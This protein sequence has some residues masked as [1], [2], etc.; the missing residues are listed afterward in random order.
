M[1]RRAHNVFEP[2]FIQWLRSFLSYRTKKNDPQKNILKSVFEKKRFSCPVWLETEKPGVVQSILNLGEVFRLAVSS[3]R[4]HKQ[5]N[6]YRREPRRT[7]TSFQPGRCS[8]THARLR[9]IC[10]KQM[11]SVFHELQPSMWICEYKMCPVWH[12]FCASGLPRVPE[13]IGSRSVLHESNPNHVRIAPLIKSYGPG[14]VLLYQGRRSCHGCG[15]QCGS[16]LTKF[17]L[18][19]I[20]SLV[21]FL[22][23]IVSTLKIKSVFFKP[24]I[25]F[26]KRLHRWHVSWED[27]IAQPMT[28]RN[29][30]I[31]FFGLIRH[32][33]VTAKS[34]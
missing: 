23:G 29:S 21:V 1:T 4:V 25:F 30:R 6:V 13:N 34:I 5:K 32:I 2:D 15:R 24:N 19:P 18:F 9:L 20:C 16:P 17:V 27:G 3:D 33:L 11:G 7:R 14:Y 28:G 31:I 12:F 10:M 22:S 26:R 8:A